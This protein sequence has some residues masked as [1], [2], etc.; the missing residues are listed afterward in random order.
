MKTAI[1][2][3]RDVYQAAEAAAR[4]EGMSRSRLY[5]EAIQLFLQSRG[6]RRITERLN[7]V[8]A[9]T[10]SSVD[11]AFIVMQSASLGPDE[12]W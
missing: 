1:S 9:S 3:P 2:L 7:E 6:T 8:Y 10:P 5:V 4:R 11:P 12:A